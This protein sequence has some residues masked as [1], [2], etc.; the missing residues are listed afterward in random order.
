MQIQICLLDIKI[1]REGFLHGFIVPINII[2]EGEHNSPLLSALME[3]VSFT[4]SYL[5]IISIC[6]V[7]ILC[8]LRLPNPDLMKKDEYAL[9]QEDFE[10]SDE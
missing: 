3:M 1:T 10:S 2:F 6:K 9:I 7:E 8:K 5:L 4:I